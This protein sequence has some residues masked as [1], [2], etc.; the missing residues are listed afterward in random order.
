MSLVFDLLLLGLDGRDRPGEPREGCGFEE[1]DRTSS[2]ALA[3]SR[4]P[5]TIGPMKVQMPSCE[6]D[7]II[8]CD[9]V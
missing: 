9:G 5:G 6:R 4:Y 3:T 8:V 2:T 7:E 1:L